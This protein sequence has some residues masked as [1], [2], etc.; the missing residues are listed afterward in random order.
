MIKALFLTLLLSSCAAFTP[1]PMAAK[2]FPYGLYHHHVSLNIKGKDMV[3]NG[4]NKWSPEQFVVV[5]L[6][7]FDMTLINYV[8]NRESFVRNLYI[9][10]AILPLDDELALKVMELMEEMYSWD[11]SICKERVCKKNFFRTTIKIFLNEAQQA[12]KITV[13][14]EGFSVIVDVTGF[15]AL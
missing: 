3:F 2:I 13:N 8:E 1:R 9:N 12:S 11:H 6:G 7:P 5:G 10:K 4:I 14:N 15:S